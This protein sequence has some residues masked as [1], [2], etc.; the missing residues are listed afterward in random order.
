MPLLAMPYVNRILGCWLQPGAESMVVASLEQPDDPPPGDEPE[1]V[2]AGKPALKPP[3]TRL[4]P[5]PVSERADPSGRMQEIQRQLQRLGANYMI[6]ERI[7]SE[8]NSYHFRCFMPVPGTG[9]Y[10]LPFKATDPDPVR[11]MERVLGDV[12]SWSS[13]ATRTAAEGARTWR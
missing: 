4:E 6:L 1:S 11:A 9:V 10:E 5:A 2:S 12:E 8:A 7:G 3:P 13:A